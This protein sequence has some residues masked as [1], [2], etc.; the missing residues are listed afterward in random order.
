MNAYCSRPHLGPDDYY[1]IVWVWRDTPDCATNHDLSYARS[2][3]L[4]HWETAAG[5]PLTLPI[6]LGVP[7]IVDPVPPR[8]GLINGG[9]RLGFDNEHR[10]VVVY[11]KYDPQGHT[12]I[13]AARFEQ[14]RWRVRQISQWEDY[15]WEFSGGGSIPFEVRIQAVVCLGN[16]LQIDCTYGRGRDRWELDANTLEPLTGGQGNEGRTDSEARWLSG[17]TIFVAFAGRKDDAQERFPGLQLR[18]AADS[19]P[20]EPDYAYRLEWWTLGKNRDKPRSGPLPPPSML[21]VLKVSR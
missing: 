11:H 18:S 14:D 8:G 9:F 6:T 1:H 5:Q 19:G 20:G 3:D 16:R 17:R 4:V 15:R 13:Y 21:R 10:P 7:T 2:R 12:Q